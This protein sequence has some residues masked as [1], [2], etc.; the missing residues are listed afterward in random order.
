[1]EEY[2]EHGFVREYKITN[3]TAGKGFRVFC[4]GLVDEEDQ[5]LKERVM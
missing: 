2:L 5:I 4:V 1:L 3:L